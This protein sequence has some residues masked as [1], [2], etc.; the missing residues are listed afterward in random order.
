MKYLQEQPP[1]CY[2][3]NSTNPQIRY[4][5]TSGGIGTTIV[6]YLLEE[7]I[8]DYALTI[9]CFTPKMAI[10]ELEELVGELSDN[11]VAM[12]II[13][14]RVRSFLYNNYVPINDRQK[15]I[16]TVNLNPR[17]NG[18]ISNKPSHLHNHV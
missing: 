18:I 13:R 14:A 3:G 4:K 17:D 9:S 16:N 2:I 12:S 5:A 6:K 7:K 15:I 10:T 8:V 1:K 11:P